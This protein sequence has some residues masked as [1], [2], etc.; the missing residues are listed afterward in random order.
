MFSSHFGFVNSSFTIFFHV[1]V[2]AIAPIIASFFPDF[3][4]IIPLFVCATLPIL[5][6]WMLFVIANHVDTKILVISI[7]LFAFIASLYAVAATIIGPAD[8]TELPI[9]VS[10]QPSAFTLGIP[11]LNFFFVS[12]TGT[13]PLL[14]SVIMY[15][16]AVTYLLAGLSAIIVEYLYGFLQPFLPRTITKFLLQNDM[17]IDQHV[18]GRL[19]EEGP[20][21]LNHGA[22]VFFGLLIAFI[23]VYSVALV[24]FL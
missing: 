11:P 24:P 5:I 18:F 6:F 13:A 19:E 2:L 7:P 23:A 10:Q 17:A 16:G 22:Y 8:S 12:Y 1:A 20:Y 3:L 4:G 15:Y 9:L 21:G 14:G